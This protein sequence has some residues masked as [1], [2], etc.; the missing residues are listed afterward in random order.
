[1][2]TRDFQFVLRKTR[3]DVAIVE[4]KATL[5]GTAEFQVEVKIPAKTH[6]GQSTKLASSK[7]HPPRVV[8]PVTTLVPIQTKAKVK[9][10]VKTVKR[11]ARKALVKARPRL[12]WIQKSLELPP[13]THH[14]FLVTASA[15]TH[16]PM[17][18]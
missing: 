1:M 14:L 10:K 5:V 9:V 6:P 8:G 18:T 16:G 7:R 13:L 4:R 15:S 3:T 11:E 2:L 17:S 12:S